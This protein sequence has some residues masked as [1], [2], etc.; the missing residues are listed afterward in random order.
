MSLLIQ[1]PYILSS[2]FLPSFLPPFFILSSS[3]LSLLRSGTIG[4]TWLHKLT[5]LTTLIIESSNPTAGNARIS[6]K[7]SEVED[8]ITSGCKL[9]VNGLFLFVSVVY[10]ERREEERREEN[11]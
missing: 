7:L 10:E 5:D 9:K 1:V 2:S 3:F 11:M 6:G 8:G 4:N